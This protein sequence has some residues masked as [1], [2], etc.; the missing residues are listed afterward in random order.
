MP[1][2]VYPRKNPRIPKVKD[3]TNPFYGMKHTKAT[4][5]Q[6]R[7]THL[8]LGLAKRGIKIVYIHYDSIW[9]VCLPI[10]VYSR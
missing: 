1:K 10:S 3:T 7:L 2:G 8:K 6:M 4:L 9:N 5:E